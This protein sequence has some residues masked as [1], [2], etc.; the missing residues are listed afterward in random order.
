MADH[1]LVTG[2]LIYHQ[3]F[4]PTLIGAAIAVFTGVIAAL[5]ASRGAIRVPP[6]EALGSDNTPQPWMSWPAAPCSGC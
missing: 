3:N 4:I 6:V 1:G 2:G 5:I